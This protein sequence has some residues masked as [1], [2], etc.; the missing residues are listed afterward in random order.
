[1]H[2]IMLFV[3]LLLLR[4]VTVVTVVAMCVDGVYNMIWRALLRILQKEKKN[5]TR[6][7][8][9]ND[10]KRRMSRHAGYMVKSIFSHSVHKSKQE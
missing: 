5:I 7:R 1:M 10:T 9:N 8:E 2:E 6:P 3:L 4:M